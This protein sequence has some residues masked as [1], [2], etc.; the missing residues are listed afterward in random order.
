MGVVFR[1]T[2][3]LESVYGQTK[4]VPCSTISFK[5]F[6]IIYAVIKK[7]ISTTGRG[8]HHTIELLIF[9][10]IIFKNCTIFLTKIFCGKN[11]EILKIYS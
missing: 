10:K 11:F 7:C 9:E 8:G 5:S 4:G 1:M 6:P 3:L 2:A